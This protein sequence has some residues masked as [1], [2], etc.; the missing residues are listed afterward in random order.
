MLFCQEGNQEVVRLLIMICQ[1]DSQ[2]ENQDDIRLEIMTYRLEIMT[3]QKIFN[4]F[5][6][7]W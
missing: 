1:E 5:P 6:A 4:I 3:Y 2:E 7:K